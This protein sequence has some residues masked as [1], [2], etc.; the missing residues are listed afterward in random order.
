MC[1]DSVV[2]RVLMFDWWTWENITYSMSNIKKIEKKRKKN[3][4]E[5]NG[6]KNQTVW[7]V[8]W[9]CQIDLSDWQSQKWCSNRW[10]VCVRFDVFHRHFCIHFWCVA[11]K[12]EPALPP[13]DLKQNVCTFLEYLST[14]HFLCI[15][16]HWKFPIFILLSLFPRI[17]ISL[18][19]SSVY[20]SFY[21]NR[22]VGRFV[23]LRLLRSIL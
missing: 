6:S 17:F 9:T 1:S 21:K 8:K 22:L 16:K 7:M 5:K 18:P 19:P 13:S 3:R 23:V 14:E 15:F 11:I 12:I 10:C 20:V 2:D 4:N